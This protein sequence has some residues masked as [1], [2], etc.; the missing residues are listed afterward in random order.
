MADKD[1]YLKV[2]TR[3]LSDGAL[4]AIG[5]HDVELAAVLPTHLPA[6]ELRVDTVW[7]MVD[8]RIFHLEF[9]SQREST[10]Y[11][12]L[13][14]DARLVRHYEAPAIRTVILYHVPVSPAPASMDLGMIQYRVEN[15][16]L[17]DQDGDAAL[18][19]VAQHLASDAWEPADRL[20]LAL[21]MTMRAEDRRALFGQTVELIA[22][23]PTPDEGDLVA[24]AI[25][26][27]AEQA[28][29]DEEIER[30]GKELRKVSKILDRTEQVGI[31]KGRAE[32]RAE[33]LQE[34]QVRIARALLDEGRPV[35]EVVRITGLTPGQVRALWPK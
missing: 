17:A 22:Q 29:T 25:M 30:L 20:R 2:L 6:G 7:R 32:G 3:S 27:L 19:V 34:A 28:L 18:G 21:A 1:L 5:V 16:Y 35:A 9:Q 14:Y 11:R 10:L 23:V 31:E 12:F 13:E 15:V 33:G 4:A 24:A 8:G 26:A